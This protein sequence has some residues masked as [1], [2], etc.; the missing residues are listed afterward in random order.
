[1]LSWLYITSQGH[2]CMMPAVPLGVSSLTAWN[3]GVLGFQLPVMMQDFP[4][5]DFPIDSRSSRCMSLFFTFF[6]GLSSRPKHLE[7]TH[8]THTHTEHTQEHTHRAEA[9]ITHT[10]TP[11]KSGTRWKASADSSPTQYQAS[12]LYILHITEDSRTLQFRPSIGSVK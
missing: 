12:Q 5:E 11:H 10:H 7:H 9:Q 3:W 2:H 1:M 6:P 8:R 4:S